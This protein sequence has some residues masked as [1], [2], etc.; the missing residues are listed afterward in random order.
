MNYRDL[1]HPD[2]QNY[3]HGCDECGRPCYPKRC[4]DG[5]LR[6]DDC[7]AFNESEAI[8][9]KVGSPSATVQL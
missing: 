1:S 4:K 3:W 2:S 9:E 7:I 8:N 6:C 5:I